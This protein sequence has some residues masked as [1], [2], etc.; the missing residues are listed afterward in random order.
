MARLEI[1]IKESP[2]TWTIF[3]NESWNASL[4]EIISSEI[5]DS[6]LFDRRLLTEG[7]PSQ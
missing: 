6:E 5:Y 3:T 4:T 2:E 7:T 1:E